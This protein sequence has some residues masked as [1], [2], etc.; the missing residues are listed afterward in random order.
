VSIG[1]VNVAPG[2]FAGAT[3]AAR[4]AAEVKEVAKRQP[5]SAWAVDRRKS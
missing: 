2:R 4:A 1:I 5:G 3:A